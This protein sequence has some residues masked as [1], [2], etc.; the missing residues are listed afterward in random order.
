M[1]CKKSLALS[2]AVFAA[3][4]AVR[5]GAAIITNWSFSSTNAGPFNTLPATTG[6]GVGTQ[7]GMTN[8]YNYAN[9]E[10]PGATANCD[11]TSVSTTA[12]GTVDTWRIRGNSNSK[13]AG[14]GNANGW[15]NSAPNYTQGAEFAVSTVGYS[16][17]IFSFDWF[18]TTQGVGNMQIQYTTNGTN[19]N[20]LGSDYLAT[21]NDEYG[22]AGATEPNLTVSVPSAGGDANF[23]VRVVSVKP[24]VGDSDY[25]ATGPGGDGNYAAA[26]GDTSSAT[27]VDYNNNSG[28]WSF[29][30]I[31]IAGTAAVPEP[32]SAGLLAL[33]AMMTARRRGRRST[34]HSDRRG[35][36][37]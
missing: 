30:N 7:L 9:G 15:N 11:I 31:T 1:R 14:A 27:A 22:G 19:W 28:N 33:G 2:M 26:S 24:V 23:A 37:H 21:A 12:F 34:I 25:S 4:P 16:N 20:N 10:G 35:C 5:A 8:D 6:P 18:C 36:G 13:N 3:I 17:I 29:G 32:A